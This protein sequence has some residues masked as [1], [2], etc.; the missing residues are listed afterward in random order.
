MR[1][2]FHPTIAGWAVSEVNSDVP[3]GYNEATLLPVLFGRVRNYGRRPPSPLSAWGEAM[4]CALTARTVVFLSAPGY[5]EEVPAAQ[6]C[7]VRYNRP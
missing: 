5:L 6:A 7:V 1:F 2:D 3:G 4:E